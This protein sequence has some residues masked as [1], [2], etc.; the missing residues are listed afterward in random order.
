MLPMLTTIVTKWRQ[1]IFCSVFVLCI[2]F[3]L[4][5]HKLYQKVAILESDKAQL[6]LAVEKAAE[7]LEKAKKSHT[8]T[9]ETLSTV[10]THLDSLNT[11]LQRD[12]SE[13]CAPSRATPQGD[14]NDTVK[15]H[16]SVSRT[17]RL[18]ADLSRLLDRAYCEGSRDDPY[19]R[20]QGIN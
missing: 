1:I 4:T 5:S 17:G 9:L 16:P 3:G 14:N 15:T 7:G 8:A 20:S 10:H 11:G 18:D 12:L 13:L 2:L 6:V 19:C